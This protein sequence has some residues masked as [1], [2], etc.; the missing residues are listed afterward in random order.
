MRHEDYMPPRHPPRPTYDGPERRR[1]GRDDVA[2]TNGGTRIVIDLSPNGLRRLKHIMNRD[3][4]TRAGALDVA[5]E[6]YAAEEAD[7]GMADLES[8]VMPL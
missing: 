3:H 7:T 2:L 4:L 5:L 8:A 6:A 1:D